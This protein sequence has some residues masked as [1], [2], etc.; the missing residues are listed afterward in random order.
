MAPE[1]GRGAAH[2]TA[3]LDVFALGLIAYE[4]LGGVHPFPMP[5]VLEALAGRELPAPPPLP[6][7]VPLAVRE[8]LAACLHQQPHGR[9]TA[10]EVLEVVARA[11]R[12]PRPGV[13]S[14]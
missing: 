8:V 6:A 5:P 14:E 11:P 7:T 13:A 9:P 2:L 1:A 4:L 3:K 12:P 10:A